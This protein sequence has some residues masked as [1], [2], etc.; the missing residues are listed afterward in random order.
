M[1]KRWIF[2]GMVVMWLWPASVW[3]TSPSV[4]AQEMQLVALSDAQM[5][6]QVGQFSKAQ[7]SAP[8]SKIILWDETAYSPKGN[9]VQTSPTSS[10][11]RS[12]ATGVNHGYRTQ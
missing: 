10:T 8:P 12:I 9:D 3:A 11:C 5:A 4:K 2:L 7:L 1:T 6:N